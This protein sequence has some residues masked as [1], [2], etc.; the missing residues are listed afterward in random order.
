MDWKWKIAAN[1]NYEVLFTGKDS[2]EHGVDIIVRLKEKISAI[3]SKSDRVIF[4]RLETLHQ[5]S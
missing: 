1:E 3:I 2:H 5:S 4:V